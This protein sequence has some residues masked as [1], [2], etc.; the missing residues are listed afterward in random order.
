[1]GLAASDQH[2]LVETR[3]CPRQP[4]RLYHVVFIYRDGNHTPAGT[5]PVTGPL[6]SP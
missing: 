3:L 5:P 1:M 4:L 2:V 6:W